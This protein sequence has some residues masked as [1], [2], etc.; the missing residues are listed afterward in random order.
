VAFA[1]SLDGGKPFTI[2]QAFSPDRDYLWLDPLFGSPI[3]LGQGTHTLLVTYAG[4]K[5]DREAVVDA[6]MIVPAIACKTFE[7]QNGEFLTL[8]HDMSTAHTTWQE[9]P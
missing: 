2:P 3:S 6:F 5:I 1:V 8:C 9:S 4:E 7:N